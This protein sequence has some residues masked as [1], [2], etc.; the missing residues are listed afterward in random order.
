MTE[1]HAMTDLVKPTNGAEKI[2]L[3]SF[4][5]PYCGEA[6]R[7]WCEDDDPSGEGEPW[8]EYVR[9]DIAAARIRELEEALKPFATAHHAIQRE[10][11]TIRDVIGPSDLHRA[12]ALVK[13]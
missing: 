11:V 2:Y 4:E 3:D 6:G 12:A 5:G 9:H 13:P 10:G 7:L 1:D 8:I